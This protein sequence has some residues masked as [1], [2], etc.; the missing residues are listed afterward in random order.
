[1]VVPLHRLA[2]AW[3][4]S[5]YLYLRFAQHTTP[6]SLQPFNA[7]CELSL[8]D[9]SGRCPRTRV[10]LLTNPEGKG[11]D[12]SWL[13]WTPSSPHFTSWSTIFA[14]LIEPYEADPVLMPPS[15]VVRSSPSLSSLGGRG[16]PA[17]GTSTATPRHI[18]E[19]HSLLSQTVPSSTGSCDS[20]LRTSRRSL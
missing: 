12:S 1:M 10:G 13:T 19:Q 7:W 17:K 18:C 4:S 6:A 14:S 9:L 15:V 5:A 3:V 2:P 20:M 8:E 16:S 11:T